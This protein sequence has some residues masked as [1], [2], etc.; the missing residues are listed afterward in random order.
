MII[1]IDVGGTHTDAVLIRDGRLS[2]KIKLLTR[3]D[4][5]MASLLDAA[6]YLLE[7]E[8]LSRIERLAISTTLSTNAIVER[9][10]DRVGM[11]ISSGPG[12][13][14]GQLP[15][16]QDT[17]YVSGY[18]NHRGIEVTPLKERELDDILEDFRKKGIRHAGVAGKFSCRN[19]Q[20][21]IRIGNGLKGAT[22]HVSLGHRLSGQLN[23][24]R[25]MA[26]AYLNAAIWSRH[27]Q[28]VREVENFMAEKRITAPCYI[29]KADG[30]TIELPQSVDTPA[31]TILS[32]P[33]ASIMG[34]LPFV[35]PGQ[36]A[37]I[38][39]IGGTT[40]DIAVL[41][42]GVPLLEPLGVTLGGYKTLIRGLRTRSIGIGGDSTV[43]IVQGR[44]V[45]GPERT[46]P[47]VAFG[48]PAPTPT[49]AMVASGRLP[50]GDRKASEQALQPLAEQM[51]RS[52]PETA[53]AIFSL[54]CDL[55]AQAVTE[56][57]E[58]I[59]SQPVYTIHE[60][61]EG[62]TVVPKALY[63][64]GGPAEVM[65]APLGKR[66]GWSSHVPGNAEVANA[67]GVAL[68]RTTAEVALLADT[69]RG[70]L[71]FAEEGLQIPVSKRFS[72]EEAIDLAREKLLEKARRLGASENDMDM[73]ITE[74][75]VFPMVRDFYAT[76]K[77]IRIKV[78]IKPGLASYLKSGE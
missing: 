44:I 64:V 76:G 2:K 55:I 26:T 41:A 16:F 11:V 70:I 74:D 58:D 31:Q 7:G 65:A 45:I 48:G 73:E 54:T 14:P 33:A 8:D 63:A 39:D 25:R 67:I 50:L 71:T 19:P 27:R 28:F 32:G 68:S 77:N 29:L 36:D 43:K 24:P 38:L 23:F 12:L 37:V 60:L 69:E 59:N 22:D 46:G 15:K 47:A 34:T 13:S 21:E 56:V 1:G 49:D 61:L 17:Y 9:K 18:M 62:K 57:M 6:D 30:G 52:L 40:T 3:Q 5:L 75:L 72:R 20:Q 51:K 66:L 53:E 42:D 35:E 78:Q 10:I 4:H